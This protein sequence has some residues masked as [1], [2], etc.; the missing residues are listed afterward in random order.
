[1]DSVDAATAAFAAWRHVPAPARGTILLRFAQLLERDKVELTE[2]MSREM[3]KVMAEAGGDVQE[4]I[5]TC[6]FV[7]S[8]G[9]RLYGQTVP[10]EMQRKELMTYRRPLGATAT[11]AADRGSVTSRSGVPSGKPPPLPT[12]RKLST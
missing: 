2:L 4:A 6:H 5:D 11:P 1:M 10:S 8:E 12:S 9:R 3:G 7:Q